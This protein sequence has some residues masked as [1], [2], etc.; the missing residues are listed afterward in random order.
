MKVEQ[1]LGGLRR[2]ERRTGKRRDEQE[3]RGHGRRK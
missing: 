3:R 1:A 2:E